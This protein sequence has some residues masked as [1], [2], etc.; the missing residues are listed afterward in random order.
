MRE[1]KR[2]N[3]AVYENKD[4][5]LGLGP[6]TLAARQKILEELSNEIDD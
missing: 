2:R 1:K 5:E 6:F 3:G 4:G